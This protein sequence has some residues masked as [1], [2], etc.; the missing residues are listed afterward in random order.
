MIPP[1]RKKGTFRAAEGNCSI[2]TK[3]RVWGPAVGSGSAER[4]ATTYWADLRHGK[5]REK[6]S[7][8]GHSGGGAPDGLSSGNYSR[9]RNV[10]V[11]TRRAL[12]NGGG[13]PKGPRLNLQKTGKKGQE[14][15]EMKGL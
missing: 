12:G 8:G 13:L 15:G 2:K 11:G 14:K 1:L 6:N 9:K 3:I 4:K 10:E 5:K 7:W